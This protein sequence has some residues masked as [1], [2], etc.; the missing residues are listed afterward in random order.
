MLEPTAPGVEPDA[1]FRDQLS[2]AARSLA[3]ER[4][5]QQTLDEIVERAQQMV[6][7][8]HD[9]GISLVTSGT[10]STAAATGAGVQVGDQMQYDLSEG[11][12]LD[13]IRVEEVVW[14]GDV[15]TDARWPLWGPRVAGELGVRSMLCL[16][17]Y[18]SQTNHGALNLYSTD[19]DAFSVVDRTLVEAFA[20]VAAAAITSARTGEHL[21]AAAASRLIIGQAQGLL[22]E[23]F[24]LSPSSAFSVLSRISQETNTKLALVAQNLVSTRTFPGQST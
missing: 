15:G 19:V 1:L 17:L 16:Q 24:G 5:V 10:I 3:A 21:H 11:P 20:A 9:A 12:C 14:S 2:E 23:R 7:G 22:M 18:T 8:C 13:A 4:T 6:A